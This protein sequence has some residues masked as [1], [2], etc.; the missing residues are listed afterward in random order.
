VPPSHPHRTSAN[1]RT[2]TTTSSNSPPL[3]ASTRRH[4][5]NEFLNELHLDEKSYVK[6][7]HA[8]KSRSTAT[9]STSSSSKPSNRRQYIKQVL[10]NIAEND[11]STKEVSL[12]GYCFAEQENI[13]KLTASLANNTHI[14]TLY[15]HEC[16]IDD[17][18]ASI[19]AFALRKNES[20]QQ[21]WLKGNM[22]GD[23]GASAL[24][25][26]LS[27]NRTLRIL[28]LNDNDIGNYGGSAIKQALK[29]NRVVTDVFLRGNQ[30]SEGA[31]RDIYYYCGRN[32]EEKLGKKNNTSTSSKF[33]L[34]IQEQFQGMK[35]TVSKRNSVVAK[36]A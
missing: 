27:E 12:N 35:R 29:H 15:L 2:S 31:K 28:G 22:I 7:Q 19:L 26:A 3:Q 30:I 20:I 25:S 5:V 11:P 8:T 13:L 21:L 34:S 24:A 6:T 16:G 9:T 36:C 10:K 32:F 1:K 4:H 18:G 17:I 33:C 23:V 14:R